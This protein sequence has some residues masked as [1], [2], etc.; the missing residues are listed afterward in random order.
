MI[1][2]GASTIGITMTQKIPIA[3]PGPTGGSTSKR[4]DPWLRKLAERT[5]QVTQ[6]VSVVA[7]NQR[8]APDEGD[9]LPKTASWRR[10]QGAITSRNRP[11]QAKA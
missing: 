3:A 10:Y 8:P 1:T 6:F 9:R 5:V 11:K 2:N 7:A 4:P